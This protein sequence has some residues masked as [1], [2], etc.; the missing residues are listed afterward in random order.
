MAQF[1]RHTAGDRI[2]VIAERLRR[3]SDGLVDATFTAEGIYEHVERV[4][5]DDK[6]LVMTTPPYVSA[7]FFFRNASTDGRV[8]WPEPDYLPWDSAEEGYQRLYERTCNGGCL[9]VVLAE[10]H[11]D[12]APPT[13]MLY[14]STG[15][16]VPEGPEE[17]VWANRHDE[18]LRYAGQ[19]QLIRRGVQ[20]AP[21]P[22]E[23]PLLTGPIPDTL[24]EVSL[25]PVNLF[26]VGWLAQ[27]TNRRKPGR[28]RSGRRRRRAPGRGRHLHSRPGQ[29]HP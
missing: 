23:S 29:R 14:E 2:A 26:Q 13:A 16:A 17:R 27:A 6:T 4:A 12:N 18:V 10:Q 28:H 19:I 8:A 7:E 24:G 21:Q 25:H 3:W 11:R 9:L 20:A 22:I 1:V 5:D 15:P